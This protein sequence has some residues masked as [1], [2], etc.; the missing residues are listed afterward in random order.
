MRAMQKTFVALGALL[1]VAIVSGCG[2]S[3]LRSATTHIAAVR[4]CEATELTVL[5]VD[6]AY[7]A[8]GCTEAAVYR[9]TDQ[10]CTAADGDASQV[11]ARARSAEDAIASLEGI[12]A[13][14]MACAGGAPVTAQIL[15][16]SDGRPGGLSLAP[17]PGG[18]ARRCVGLLVYEARIAPGAPLLWSHRF[19]GPVSETAIAEP[20]GEGAPVEG[21]ATDDAALDDGATDDTATDGGPG[22]DDVIDDAPSE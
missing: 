10:E 19:G 11:T 7:E 1:V 21:A 20:T 16:G 4:G 9:C 17:D 6:G 12:D 22:D 8:Y 13:D 3:A 18:D 2:G 14:V 15:F 5:E